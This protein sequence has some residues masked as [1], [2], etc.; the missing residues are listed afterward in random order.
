MGRERGDSSLSSE[1][2]PH[3]ALNECECRARIRYIHRDP[4]VIAECRRYD[5]RD[6]SESPLGACRDCYALEHRRSRL[7]FA[8][9]LRRKDSPAT[10]A[11]IPCAKTIWMAPRVS[12]ISTP[13]TSSPSGS[14]RL[15]G[16]AHPRMLRRSNGRGTAKAGGCLDGCLESASN[17]LT[18][19]LTKEKG[20]GRLCVTH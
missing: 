18:S 17:A 1:T 3:M 9:H 14:W 4:A 2:R 19:G 12:I 6:T 15:S 11:L 8:R 5:L 16:A 13:S 10:S 20:Y 7:E